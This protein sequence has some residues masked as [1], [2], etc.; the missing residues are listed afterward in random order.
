MNCV[1]CGNTSDSYLCEKCLNQTNIEE[2]CRQIIEYNIP[3]G[4]NS[5]WNHLIIDSTDMYAQKKRIVFSISEYLISPRKEYIQILFFTQNK[6]NEYIPKESRPWLYETYE[7]IK[8]S[9][10]LTQDELQYV[11]AV[12][13]SAYANDYCYQQAEEIAK[14]LKNHKTL[15]KQVYYVLGEYYIKTRR[16]E[17]AQSIL[18]TGAKVYQT[19]NFEKMRFDELLDENKKR[20]QTAETGSSKNGKREYMPASTEGKDKYVEFLYTLGIDVS[21]PKKCVPKP[22][23]KDKYPIPVETK[24]DNFTSFVAF[25]LETTGLDSKT[26]SII[27]IGAIKVING[28]VVE[29]KDFIFQEFVRPYKSSVGPKITELTGITIDDVKDARQMWEVTTDFL[30]FVGD[31]NL[32]GYNSVSFDSRFLMR[33]GR[34]SR[35]IIKN[36][37]FDVKYYAKEILKSRR[38]EIQDFKLNT[39]AEYL[40]IENPR[41]HR[42]LADAITT[43]KIFLRLKEL[44][45]ISHK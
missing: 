12:A 20:K 26:D 27:E 45:N 8:N 21:I 23:S 13:L 17:E 6:K 44:K 15:P 36:K 42:A 18:L 1:N 39:I 43:A 40:G 19:E 38:C 32:V 14:A 16:Y 35:T 24:D 5:L 3:H 37:H 7:Q 33:A 2:L 10:G 9:S 28:Q 4:D 30:N 22:I 25:D 11:S 29:K 34:Y 31:L 41:A